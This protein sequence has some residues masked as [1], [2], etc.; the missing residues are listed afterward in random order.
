MSA[1]ASPP[2]PWWRLDKRPV[3][4]VPLGAVALFVII[5]GSTSTSDLCSAASPCGPDWLG[6]LLLGLLLGS[7]GAVF[8]HRWTAFLLAVALS[9]LWEFIAWQSSGEAWWLQLAVL[10]YA[11]LCFRVADLP[12]APQAPPALTLPVPAPGGSRH[13]LGRGWRLVAA[14]L[15]LGGTG[16]TWGTVAQQHRVES[17][18]GAAQVV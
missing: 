15:V 6:S 18:E 8:L 10:G 16:V 7:A 17:Q 5:G 11:A 9:V 14:A 2:L 3:A 13:R 1:A 4:W 12:A